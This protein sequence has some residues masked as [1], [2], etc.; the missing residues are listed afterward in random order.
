MPRIPDG[1]GISCLQRAETQLSMVTQGGR[2][3][4]RECWQSQGDLPRLHHACTALDTGSLWMWLASSWPRLGSSSCQDG[5]HEFWHVF[6]PMQ[7]EQKACPGGSA[8]SSMCREQNAQSIDAVSHGLDSN[9]Q[10]TQVLTALQACSCSHGEQQP[11]R[12]S[13]PLQEHK[14]HATMEK[15]QRAPQL[16]CAARCKADA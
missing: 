13:W 15:Q 1:Q 16:G 5:I 10:H 4:H 6:F 14:K 12:A 8:A 9:W 11:C 2:P 7:T 3:K